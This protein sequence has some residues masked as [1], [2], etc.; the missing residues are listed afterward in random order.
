V[1]ANRDGSRNRTYDIITGV[2]FSSCHSDTDKEVSPEFY[3]PKAARFIT[4]P[5]S[6]FRNS[7]TSPVYQSPFRDLN[8][9]SSAMAPSKSSTIQKCLAKL[10]SGASGAKPSLLPQPLKKEKVVQTSSVKMD[11]RCCQV[12]TRMKSMSAQTEAKRSL[13]THIQTVKSTC[14]GIQGLGFY[15]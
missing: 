7:C 10:V 6:K 5:S 11:S 9:R 1:R 12:S 8:E 3:S 4:N 15:W 13:S 2:D 14:R